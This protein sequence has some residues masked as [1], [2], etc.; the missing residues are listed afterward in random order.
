V[1]VSHTDLLDAV[2]RLGLSGKA[3]CIHCSV[4]SFGGIDGGPR[5]IIDAFLAERATVLV[6]TFSW[7]FFVI[8]PQDQRPQR[9]GSRYEFA[10]RTSATS[11]YTPD[12]TVIDAAMGALPAA[13]LEYA[14]HRR[15]LHPLCSFAAVGPMASELIG[16]QKPDDVWSPLE[17][18]A[19]HDGAVLLMGVDLTKLTLVHLAEKQAGRRPFIRWALGPSGDVIS[20]QVGGCSDGFSKFEPVVSQLTTITQVGRSRWTC[21]PAKESLLALAQA[22]IDWPQITQCDDPTCE[23]C[24]DGVAGGPLVG[25]FG[26]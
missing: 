4:R 7:E 6:P 9:N 2:K 21:L 18:L 23:R 8:P 16:P 26:A 11:V 13:V 5:A 14:E 3:V 17:S 19:R 15:G 22:I 10:D 20:V 1:T 25:A 24:L 12:S